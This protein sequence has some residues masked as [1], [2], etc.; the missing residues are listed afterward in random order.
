MLHAADDPFMTAD[1]IPT[2][3]KI[4]S[5]VT[6]ELHDQGGHV[7][8]INGGNPFKPKYY[9]EQRILNFLLSPE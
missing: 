2:E 3:D 6:Y 8:F 5:H 7:G 9:L 1:V 4:S